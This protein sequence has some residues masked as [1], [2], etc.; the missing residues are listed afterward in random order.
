MINVVL[1]LGLLGKC[2]LLCRFVCGYGLFLLQLLFLS[3]LVHVCLDRVCLCS[4]EV[5]VV[6]EGSGLVRCV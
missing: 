4:A 1:T 5:S 3:Y 6:N 2:V